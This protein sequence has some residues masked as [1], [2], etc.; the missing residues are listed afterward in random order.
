MTNNELSQFLVNVISKD[1]N[2]KKYLPSV[3]RSYFAIHDT[4][5]HNNSTI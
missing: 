2:E 5:N 1:W 3:L 4:F